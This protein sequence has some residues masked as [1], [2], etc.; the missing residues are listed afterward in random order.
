MAGSRRSTLD[1]VPFDRFTLLSFGAHERWAEAVAGVAEVPLAQVRVGVDALPA[2]ESW[3]SICE[4]GE[5]GALL[6]RPDQHVA[7]RAPSLPEDA[8]G[9]LAETRF[10]RAS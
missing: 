8:K 6:V 3:R 4:V 7:W 2:D 1:L 9:R 5:T 10:S